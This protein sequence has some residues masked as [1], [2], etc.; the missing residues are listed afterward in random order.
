LPRRHRRPD[1]IPGIGFP[2]RGAQRGGIAAHLQGIPRRSEEFETQV[3]MSGWRVV[4]KANAQFREEESID[5]GVITARKTV[6]LLVGA[7][8]EK[9]AP[10]APTSG[11][12]GN[13]FH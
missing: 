5:Y 4:R 10:C 12:F 9:E 3:A 7:D 8:R 13:V 11:A 2:G 1:Q 6:V